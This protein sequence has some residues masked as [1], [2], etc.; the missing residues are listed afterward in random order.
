MYPDSESDHRPDFGLKTSGSIVLPAGVNNV[1]GIK[2]TVGL[3]SR[4]MVVPVSQRQDTIGPLARTV[5][6]AAKILQA[7]AG[8]DP[9]DNYTQASPFANGLPDY[10]A[11]CKLSA[12]KGK[13]I[14]IP[15]NAIEESTDAYDAPILAA[16]EKAILAM[17][18]AGAVIVENTNFTAYSEFM[19]DTTPQAV[20]LIDF[21][22]NLADYISNLQTNPDKLYNLED[23]RN[24]TWHNPLEE[25]PS[26]DTEAWDIA[27]EF[28]D[29]TSGQFWAMFQRN[30][31]YGGEGGVLGAISRHDLDA[32]VLPTLIAPRVPALVGSPVITVPLGSMPSGSPI[33]KNVRG[34]LIDS[35]PGVPFGISFLGAKW[36]EETLIGIAYAF[37]QRTLHREKLRHYIE[38]KTELRDIIDAK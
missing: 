13:R 3:T 36:S 26:R 19:M 6:D 11:A 1:V 32:V 31:H 25:Y 16:F 12:L 33:V 28:P 37:E 8:G 27:L 10:T 24:F 21:K 4:Y 22:Q 15:R 34:N 29:N 9:R 30:L 17:S 14:G 18:E 2:P 23:I 7:I 20:P 5:K 35:A 38:P